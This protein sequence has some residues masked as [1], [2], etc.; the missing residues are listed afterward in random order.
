VVLSVK[1]PDSERDQV[2]TGFAFRL[3]RTAQAT[4]RNSARNPAGLPGTGQHC[5]PAGPRCGL[6]G[7]DRPPRT[8]VNADALERAV[9]F[10]RTNLNSQWQ[11]GIRIGAS[12]SAMPFSSGDRD[13]LQD[14][15]PR[16]YRSTDGVPLEFRWS[17]YAV[18]IKA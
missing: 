5:L 8:G 7:R 15:G 2:P 11:T 4:I 10:V 9:E 16:Q 17:S 6:K 3:G 18:L 1:E 13:V 14:A 12:Y